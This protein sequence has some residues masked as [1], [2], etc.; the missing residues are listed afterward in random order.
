MWASV[1]GVRVGQRAGA[2]VRDPRQTWV[3]SATAHDTHDATVAEV[4]AVTGSDWRQCAGCLGVDTELFFPIGVTGPAVE[5]AERA[6]AVCAGCSVRGECLE[7][8]LATGQHDGIWGGLGE[9]ERRALRRARQR[10][11]ASKG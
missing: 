2:V 10:R 3:D 4:V 11:Q 8:A 1:V 6:K 5:Q 9:D 7:W